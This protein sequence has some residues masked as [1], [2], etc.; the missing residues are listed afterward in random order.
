MRRANY[1]EPQC[2]ASDRDQQREEV[3]ER[4]EGSDLEGSEGG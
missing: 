2:D 3:S 1:G 4:A